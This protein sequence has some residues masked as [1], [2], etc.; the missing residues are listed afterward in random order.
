MFSISQHDKLSHN[1]RSVCR[2]LP[3]IFIPDLLTYSMTTTEVLSTNRNHIKDWKCKF[4][5]FPE[6]ADWHIYNYSWRCFTKHKPHADR[7][8]RALPSTRHPRR[9]RNG[10]DVVCCCLLHTAY[11]SRLTVYY[12]WDD[13][14]AFRFVPGDLDLWPLTFDLDI[15]T[16]P[17]Q[18][19]NTSSL[20]IWRKSVRRSR[21]IW[22][23]NKKNK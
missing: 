1:R 10:N 17:S 3:I 20:W 18:G 8:Q 5:A 2:T 23:T 4:T 15:Q 22:G 16:R 14:T 6:F 11:D 9:P 7:C 19:P 12:Q 21:D 13:S